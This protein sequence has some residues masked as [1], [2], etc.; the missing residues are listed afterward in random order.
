MKNLIALLLLFTLACTEITEV[1]DHPFSMNVNGKKWTG[2]V[3]KNEVD[4]LN[5]AILSCLGT[6]GEIFGFVIPKY[7]GKNQYSTMQDSLTLATLIKTDSTT[8]IG[9]IQI[10]VTNETVVSSQKKIH[11]VFQANLYSI[12]DSLIITEGKF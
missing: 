2:V 7:N 5:R 9:K 12:S 8:Y 6:N 11:G 1:I 10:D 4:S 3:A